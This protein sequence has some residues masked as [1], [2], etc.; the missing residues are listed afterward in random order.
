MNLSRQQLFLL[1][2]IR[3]LGCVRREQLYIMAGQALGRPGF[4]CSRRQVDAMLRQLR[5]CLPDVRL[6]D[7]LVTLSRAPP[8]AV[9]LEAVDVMLELTSGKPADFRTV[10]SDII[11][12]RFLLESEGRLRMFAVARL[13]ETAAPLYGLD[14]DKSERVI[15]LV[16]SD[17]PLSGPDLPY[18]HFLARCREDGT[19][20]FFAR[21]EKQN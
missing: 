11:R 18:K 1:D 8:D 20:R 10:Q 15:F 21:G 14:V 13:P 2:V 16:D 7:E 12:L 9:L 4:E 19:H 17:G 3:R 5:Y 6:E